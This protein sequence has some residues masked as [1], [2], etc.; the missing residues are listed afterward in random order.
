[1]SGAV[2]PSHVEPVPLGEVAAL[3][4]VREPA[5]IDVEITGVS[6][7]SSAV[8]PGDLYVGVPG[9]RTHGARYAAAA[10]AA[11]ARALLTDDE[12]AQLLARSDVP[13][14]VVDQP[15]RVM[16]AVSALVYGHPAQAFR[17]VGVTGT[18]G[19][20]T[21]TQLVASATA[22][23]GRRT[24][25]VGTMGTWIDGEPIGSSLTTPEAP[26]LHALFAVMR[27]RAIEVCAIEVSSHALVMG[28]VDGVVFDLAVF[29]NLG[30][31]H[32]DFHADIEDYFAAKAQLFTTARAKRA[33]VNIDD[34]YGGR[35]ARSP[36]IPTETFST[37]RTEAD[38]LGVIDLAA[39]SATG[40]AFDLTGPD[41]LR[42]RCTVDMAGAFNVANAVA[43][44]AAASNLG[45]DLREAADGIA[46]AGPV[47]GRMERIS[48]GQDFS[49]I[50]DYAH[51][52]DAVRATLEALRPVTPGRLFIVLG[53]GGDRD[54]GKRP[55]M[56]E[57]AATLADVLVVTDDNPRSEDPGAIRKEILSGARHAGA[58][59]VEVGDRGAAIRYVLTDARRGDTVL[60]AGK[61][62]E[63]GQEIDDN[64]LPFD[65]HDVATAI[66]DEL[67]GVD[68]L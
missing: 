38:W 34:D 44:L 23:S 57:I 13:V 60:I 61:G 14:L 21:T 48:A 5:P 31:D 59:L 7:S 11:G 46:S 36:E 42:R 9:A 68:G 10:A 54:A 58:Q 3:V 16:G 37:S 50:I 51:K 27:E 63:T 41:G 33:L 43:A 18:Q 52:P 30:R 45:V 67:R 12:G 6:A 32:L 64:V 17:L 29:L 1:M 28:R 39:S 20:T 62:H 15:R 40:S 66:L 8:R 25:V 22:R 55:I 53:A 2:R 19:K 49:V 56:G 65:D 47:S 35:L 24:A 4:G 26:D